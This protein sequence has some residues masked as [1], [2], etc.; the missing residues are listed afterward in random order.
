MDEPEITLLKK[1][2]ITLLDY[3]AAQAL[4]AL[5][6]KLINQEP[7]N[8][9]A[10]TAYVYAKAMIKEKEICGDQLQGEVTNGKRC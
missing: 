8:T 10:F 7:I 1:S 6:G 3:F 2:E 5:I 9:I 4:P